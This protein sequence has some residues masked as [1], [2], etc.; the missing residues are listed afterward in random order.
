MAGLSAFENALEDESV[1]GRT[2]RPPA[3]RVLSGWLGAGNERVYLGRDG[4][5]FYRPDVEYL[6]GRGFLDPDVIRRRHRRS[7]AS[8]LR[9]RSPIRV[10]RFWRSTASSRRAASSLVVMPTPVKPG[11]HPERLVASASGQPS[12]LQNPSYAD[13]AA[14]LRS[15][16][17]LL[18]DPAADPGAAF[19]NRR[20]STSRPTL[21]GV[22]KRWSSWPS[23]WRRS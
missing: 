1:L 9:F 11:V 18:F 12:V 2:L 17:V 19:G 13:L 22:P 4:W 21:T 20:R 3:Q 6:T 10:R 14:W 8:G 15:Q 7:L 16:G 5:L 23:A